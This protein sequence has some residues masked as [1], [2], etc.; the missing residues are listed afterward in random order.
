MTI[1]QQGGIFGRNPTFNDVEANTLGVNTTASY[2]L[3]VNSGN[4]D[5]VARFLSTDTGASLRIEDSS[6]YSLVEYLNG[7]LN[8]YADQG[9]T[10]SNTRIRFYIDAAEVGRWDENANL[11]IMNGDL[12]LGTSGN[13]IDFSA[14]SGT[15]TSELFDDYEEGTWTPTIGGS[16]S[17]GTYTYSTQVGHYTKIGN[18]VTAWFNI[19]VSGI[20]SAGSGTLQVKGLPFSVNASFSGGANFLGIDG[21]ANDRRTAGLLPSAGNNYAVAIRGYG[22]TGSG[23]GL[24][25]TD[26][27]GDG[28]EDILA[29]LIYWV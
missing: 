29:T 19:R 22:G 16:S 8:I 11:K 17:A 15:G 23:L 28:G 27:D 3:D 13:G 9:D 26:L 14:T 20:T 1:K 24:P 10:G 5:T 7:K 4:D 25:I 12:I 2:P 21:L 18:Q 6:G